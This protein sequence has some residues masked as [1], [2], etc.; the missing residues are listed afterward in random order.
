MSKQFSKQAEKSRSN[1]STP[2]FLDGKHIQ[3]RGG[4]TYNWNRH[5]AGYV[6]EKETL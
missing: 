4:A 2:G 5:A 1:V 6:I 3:V